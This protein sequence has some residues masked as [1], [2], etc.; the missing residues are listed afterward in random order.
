MVQNPSNVELISV[1]GSVIKVE[2]VAGIINLPPYHKGELLHSYL[3]KT[4]VLNCF[5]TVDELL[6]FI[7]GLPEFRGGRNFTTGYDAMGDFSYGIAFENNFDWLHSG[8][9]FSPLASFSSTPPD[10]RLREYQKVVVL[11]D[12][13][14]SIENLIDDVFVCPDCMEEE[15]NGWYYHTEHQMPYLTYCPKHE[16]RLL[17]YA[18][19]KCCE[20]DNPT[21]QPIVSYDMEDRLASFSKA[22]LQNNITCSVYGI[23]GVINTKLEGMTNP[24]RIKPYISERANLLDCVNPMAMKNFVNDNTPLPVKDMIALIAYLFDTP[25]EFTSLLPAGADYR[26]EFYIAIRGKFEVL[27]RYCNDAV[28][29]RCLNCGDVFYVYPPA[30]I[31]NPV[32]MKEVQKYA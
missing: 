21:F 24:Y 1:K 3:H 7:Q 13:I 16:T 8:T 18:G 26:E 12:N 27:G 9:L 15:G 4:A 11:R 30:F 22:I 14:S 25:E 2:S 29:L 28:M 6:K 31:R 19:V 5:L 20:S 10:I 32:C 23:I 17:K